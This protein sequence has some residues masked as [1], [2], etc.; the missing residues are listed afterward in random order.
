MATQHFD[1][2]RFSEKTQ[3][4]LLIVA[5]HRI[6]LLLLDITTRQ[7]LNIYGGSLEKTFP[8]YAP[9]RKF[10]SFSL[11]TKE[12]WTLRLGRD[13]HRLMP[14]EAL[15]ELWTNAFSEY[16]ARFQRIFFSFQ[17][18]FRSVEDHYKVVYTDKKT[19]DANQSFKDRILRLA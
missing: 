7:Y 2:N 4:I 16:I 11:A 15:K 1:E 10:P 13:L 12:G 17:Q 5:A 14:V 9:D 18:H 8:L 6:P 19:W 3:P